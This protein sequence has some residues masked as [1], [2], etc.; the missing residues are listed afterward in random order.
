MYNIYIVILTMYI[1]PSTMMHIHT[2]LS[3][4]AESYGI[5][6]LAVQNHE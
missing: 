2:P 1:V 6:Y 4:L 5:Y 3:M